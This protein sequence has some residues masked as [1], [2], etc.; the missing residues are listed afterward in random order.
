MHADVTL[1][2]GKMELDA[3]GTSRLGTFGAD[4][5]PLVVSDVNRQY[6]ASVS[7]TVPVHS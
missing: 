5:V 2:L 6:H 4:S 7:F 3:V 1:P